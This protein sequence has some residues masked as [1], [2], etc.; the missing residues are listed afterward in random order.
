M[1]SDNLVDEKG[2]VVDVGRASEGRT[3]VKVRHVESSLSAFRV[4]IGN[5]S[6]KDVARELMAEIFEK[7]AR[8]NSQ[9]VK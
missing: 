5:M 7:L 8:T 3:F 2:F 6:T 9:E 1:T 4:G